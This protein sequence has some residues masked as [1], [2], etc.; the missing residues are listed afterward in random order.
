MIVCVTQR[1]G[2][3]Y[4]TRFA[5]IGER[6]RLLVELRFEDQEGKPNGDPLTIDLTPTLLAE[7]E[8]HPRIGKISLMPLEKAAAAQAPRPVVIKQSKTVSPV[9][10]AESKAE[11]DQII[12][13][14]REAQHKVAEERKRKRAEAAA[15]RKEKFEKRRAESR[16]PKADSGERTAQSG[17][18]ISRPGDATR[19]SAVQDEAIK[20]IAGA[21]AAK[22]KARTKPVAKPAKPSAKAAAP[23]PKPEARTPTA[24]ARKADSAKQNTRMSAA[25]AKAPARAKAQPVVPK[26][27]K[28]NARAALSSQ[29]SALSSSRRPGR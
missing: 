17:M 3:R 8:K 15:A 25:A 20:R 23:K 4:F 2:I 9:Y 5:Q 12:A 11:K 7:Y 6:D 19:I 1:R 26:N 22:E 14:V 18:R 16:E 24:R 10:L 27:G 29:L 13:R 28:A 21:L